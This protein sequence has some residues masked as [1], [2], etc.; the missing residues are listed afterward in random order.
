MV[1]TFTNWLFC[2]YYLIID[3]TVSFK[4]PKYSVKENDGTLQLVLVLSK[5]SSTDITIKV[6]NYDNTT[7]GKVLTLML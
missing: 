6:V 7:M 3:V 1:C 5:P 2:A 4:N